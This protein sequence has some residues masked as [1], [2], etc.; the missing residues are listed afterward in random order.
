MVESMV[1]TLRENGFLR[2]C[3]VMLLQDDAAGDLARGSIDST[4]CFVE[5]LWRA[6]LDILHD[7]SIQNLTDGC[8]FRRVGMQ[9][10]DQKTLHTGAI[11]AVE[12]RPNLRETIRRIGDLAI[13]VA[14]EEAV[15]AINEDLVALV[16]RFGRGPCETSDTHDQVDYAAG[17]D[18]QGSRIVGT[19]RPSASYC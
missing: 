5:A 15:P 11:D 7:N 4:L 14:L 19:C 16:L 10:S 18:V 17:P 2:R 1:K 13:R 3:M 6:A 8:A 12:D 9:H